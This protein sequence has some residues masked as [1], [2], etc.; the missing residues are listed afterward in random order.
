[1]RLKI[2]I[3]DEHTYVSPIYPDSKAEIL[4]VNEKTE[5]QYWR[6]QRDL[7]QSFFD[8]IPGL[9]V[10]DADATIYNSEGQLIQLSHEDTNIL[11]RYFLRELHRRTHGVWMM[12]K[13]VLTYITGNHYFILQWGEMHGYTNPESGESFGEYREFQRDIAYFYDII[14]K[15]E[16]ISGGFIAKAKKTGVTQFLS[17]SYLNESTL[18]KEKRFGM[19]S[20]SHED[21]KGTNMMLFQHALERLP[22]ILKPR[23]KNITLSKVVFDSPKKNVITAK[24]LRE[25]KAGGYKTFVEALPTK[26]DAL[27]G[28]KIWRAWLDEFP[29]YK[30]PFPKQLFDKSSESVKLQ[31]QIYGKMFLSSYPP[32]D[33]SRGFQEAKKIYYES[34]LSTLNEINRTKTGLFKHFVSALNATE[35]TFDKYGKADKVKAFYLN[36]ADRKS[37]GT[38]RREIQKKK[39][40]YPR[41]EK[42]CW[43]SGGSGSAFDNVRIS[44]QLAD[45]E[46]EEKN[47]AIYYRE[48]QLEWTNGFMSKVIFTERTEFEKV[49]NIESKWRFFTKFKQSE[50]NQ[51]VIKGFKDASGRLMPDEHGLFAGAVDPTDYKLKKDVVEGSKN[52]I[53]VGIADDI[54]RNTEFHKIA[55]NIIAAEY[56]FRSDDPDEFY[57]DLVMAILY[58]GM[59]VIVEANKGWVVT[60]LKKDGLQ[61][62]LLLADKKLGVIRPFREGDELSLINTTEDRINDYCRAIARHI[63]VPAE[64]SEPDYLPLIKSTRLL[65]QLM[66][67]DPNNTKKFD[68]VVSFGYLRLALES[69][70]YIKKMLESERGL[71]SLTEG[72]ID[73]IIGF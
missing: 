64:E 30:S 37:A 45:I 6:R 56:F 10:E 62:F 1:M 59:Y 40:Q 47:G 73:D 53:H 36:E 71:Y 15:N 61:N 24:N 34:S 18:I 42:E 16:N 52:S 60:R 7:P 58:F 19:V 44:A 3:D 2:A 5:N 29:K 31:Q 54:K 23:I 68:L 49:N 25:T 63:R 67:F 13:G 27:D 43:E 32:E 39:R 22:M 41:T 46:E 48:G 38:D 72:I 51:P 17:L 20:K 69:L 55:S 50:I 4:F 21:C 66:D 35:G 28:P 33:D 12:I 14:I 65:Y 26:E 8:Y 70:S 9:T 11:R 57:D